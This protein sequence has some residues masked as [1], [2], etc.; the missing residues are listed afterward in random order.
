MSI[1]QAIVTLNGGEASPL[2][3]ARSDLEK[4]GSLCRTLKNFIPRRY[5]CIE[6]R[7]GTY[8]VAKAKTFDH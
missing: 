3:D 2:I 4:Y 5:G 6:R 8:F 7:P 1:N